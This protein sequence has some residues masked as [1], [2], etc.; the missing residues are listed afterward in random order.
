MPLPRFLS[1]QRSL[2]PILIGGL[3]FIS[4]FALTRTVMKTASPDGGW[5]LHPYWYYGHF[6]H[7]GINPYMAYA[8]GLTLPGPVHYLDGSVVAPDA[9]DQPHLGH[10]PANTAPILLL[11]S[12]LSFF[13]WLQ[14]KNIWLV[15]NVALIVAIP[16]LALWLLPASLRLARPLAWLVAFSFY[17]MKGPRES[18]ASG[19]TSLLVFFLMIVT[20]LLRQSHWL[21]AGVALGVALGK[22]SLS[23]PVFLFLLLEKRFRLIAVAIGVQLLGLA[24]VSTL[25]GGSVWETIQVNLSMVAH[26]AVERGVHIGYPLREYPL[27]AQALVAVVTVATLW[28]IWRTHQRGWLAADLLPVNSALILWTLLVAYHRNYDALMVILFLILCL[29]AATT[30]QLPQRQ[31]QRLGL[32]WLVALGILCLPGE[33]LRPFV[34]DA[35]AE[36]FLLWVDRAMTV[37]MVAMLA[38]N[39]WLLPRTPR[40]NL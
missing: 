11:L 34:T 15:C 35:Q 40:V 19:Q 30:W 8:Q 12:I 28:A 13:P 18:A 27:I 31:A 17:A 14:A 21:W 5:D 33:I 36:L 2:Y 7:A 29:S 3:V 24:A 10:V 6:V 16:W 39:L 38:V 4:L 25:G 20:L 9:V 1:L 26:H 22:Y 23:L 37:A 32:F